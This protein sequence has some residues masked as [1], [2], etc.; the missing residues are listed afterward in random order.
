MHVACLFAALS[1]FL[2]TIVCAQNVSPT[3]EVGATSNPRSDLRIGP[4]LRAPLP[5]TTAESAAVQVEAE[6]ASRPSHR[7]Y[8]FAVYR[9]AEYQRMIAGRSLDD[10]M[11]DGKTKREPVASG[12]GTMN[13][14]VRFSTSDLAFRFRVHGSRAPNSRGHSVAFEI[15][16]ERAPVG[17]KQ[18]IFHFEGTAVIPSDAGHHSPIFSTASLPEHQLVIVLAWWHSS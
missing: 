4:D 13:S 9:A 7:R 5:P 1:V 18:Y 11:R 16:V 14:D 15:T 10:A 17:Q 12:G 8:T 3:P 6:R 2:S